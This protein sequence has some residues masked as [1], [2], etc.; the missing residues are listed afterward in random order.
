MTPDLVTTAQREPCEVLKIECNLEYPKKACIPAE[1]TKREVPRLDVP[2]G[3]KTP[4]L[5]RQSCPKIQ[6]Q[7]D[8][9][10]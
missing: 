5:L 3:K 2:L 7:S 8:Q 10:L 4:P 6:T 9:S 1:I